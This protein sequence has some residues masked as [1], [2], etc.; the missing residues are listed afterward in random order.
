MP[1]V[2]PEQIADLKRQHGPRL[3]LI[4]DEEAGDV[5]FKPASQEVWDE[6]V[7]ALGP[8]STASPTRTLFDACVVYPTGA[9]L[10]S[11]HDE[12]PALADA[13]A[14]QIR[15]KSGGRRDLAPKKL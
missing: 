2:T 3:Y 10:Q 14:T 8:D 5:V 9:E 11:I 7:D 1:K 13:V 12:L 4:E 15:Q 6:F